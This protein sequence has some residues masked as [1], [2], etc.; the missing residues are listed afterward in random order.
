MENMK[1][2]SVQ[3]EDPLERPEDF[4]SNAIGDESK[5][6]ELLSLGFIGRLGRKLNGS[7]RHT[8]WEPEDDVTTAL[9]RDK[10]ELKRMYKDYSEEKAKTTTGKH[11]AYVW[12]PVTNSWH[13]GIR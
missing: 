8:F 12:N 7:E 2:S 6:D 13:F 3:V 4:F 9:C 5:V 10:G 11:A 1:E